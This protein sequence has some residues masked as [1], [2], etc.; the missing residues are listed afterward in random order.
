MGKGGKEM[1]GGICGV[2]DEERYV[3]ECLGGG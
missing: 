3:G 2:G 1:D